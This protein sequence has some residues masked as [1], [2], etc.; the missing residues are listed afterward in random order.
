[1]PVTQQQLREPVPGSAS[2]PSAPPRAHGPDHAAPPPPRP[3]TRTACS[4]PASNSRTRCSAS[5]RSVLT[6]SPDA[7]RDLRRRRHHTLHATLRELAREPV[8]GRAGLIRDPHRPRQPSAEPGRRASRRPS[9]R[10][11][12][13]RLSVQDRRDDLRRVHVQTDEGSTSPPCSPRLKAKGPH[14]FW[15]DSQGCVT[16]GSGP[17]GFDPP[18]TNDVRTD[19]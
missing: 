17:T 18:P 2:D 11:E 15:Q 14:T 6:R 4:F 9:R 16:P 8:P 10:T 19:R 1:M 3:G 7:A 12:L 5:R 13:A